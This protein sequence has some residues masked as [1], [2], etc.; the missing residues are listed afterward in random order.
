MTNKFSELPDNL[1]KNIISRLALANKA[2]LKATSKDIAKY[3]D[4][5]QLSI[6]PV[7]PMF[8]A[9][10]LRIKHPREVDVLST[11]HAIQKVDAYVH[12]LKKRL[13]SS[14]FSGR[15]W[16]D[17]V[18]PRE[19]YDWIESDISGYRHRHGIRRDRLYATRFNN[20]KTRK[21]VVTP[22]DVPRNAQY[23]KSNARE[24][25]FEESIHGHYINYKAMRHRAGWE[26]VAPCR[27]GMRIR[28]I[29]AL[30]DINNPESISVYGWVYEGYKNF[31]MT[32][33]DHEV[34]PLHGKAFD[35]Y[36]LNV[37]IFHSWVN[38]N[39]T[40]I[41]SVYTVTDV[42]E[43]VRVMLTFRDALTYSG[44]GQGDT[45]Y[46]TDLDGE[47]CDR[48]GKVIHDLVEMGKLKGYVITEDVFLNCD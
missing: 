40:I 2:R 20:P 16:L 21:H 44:H 29:M 35:W 9:K 42:Q 17:P 30:S 46:I 36:S 37:M 38:N 14:P 24:S 22:S 5:A 26:I 6:G 31:R 39:N 28:I 33:V 41:K 12:H 18:L 13:E 8:D 10:T 32:G 34:A 27:G 48:A 4:K 3:M 43:F 11:A 25:Q 45:L 23:T 7:Q 15:G 19:L 47:P 1:K